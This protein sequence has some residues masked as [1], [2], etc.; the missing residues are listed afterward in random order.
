MKVRTFFLFLLVIALAGCATGPTGPTVSVIPAPGKPFEVFQAEDAGC[1]QWA[2]QQING[3]NPA[4]TANQKDCRRCSNRHGR[5]RG[6]RR[7]RRVCLGTRRSRS[8]HRRSDGPR[9]WCGCGQQCGRSLR[10][11]LQRRYN[12][13]YTQCMYSK[14][15]QVPGAYRPVSAT[16]PPPVVQEGPPPLAFA[17]PPDVALIPGTYAYFIPGIGEDIAFYGGYWYRP[18]HGHW[19]RSVSYA[20]PWGF[21]AIGAVPSVI[22]SLPAGWRSTYHGYRPIPHAEFHNNWQRW[23]RERH[24][25]RH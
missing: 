5:G 19:Y 1:R 15:N 4:Q 25:E 23:E 6:P 18:W 22:V 20:G 13:A 21:V 16:P 9:R 3:M 2:E 24:W 10:I 7:A 8:S 14:G 12:T 17:S 11:A